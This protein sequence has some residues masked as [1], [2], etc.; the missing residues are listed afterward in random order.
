MDET[1][2]RKVFERIEQLEDMY[3]DL[4]RAA[5]AL[6]AISPVNGG[7]GELDKAELIERFLRDPC[8]FESIER[9]D[10][11]DE[12]AKDGVRPNIIARVGGSS[13]EPTLWLV[14]HCDIVPPGDL[15][16]WNSNPYM[17]HLEERR[18]YGRGTEDGLQGIAASAAALRAVMDV[19]EGPRLNV[20]LLIVSDEETGHKYGIEHVLRA[21]PGLFQP[22]DLVV[23]TSGGTRDGTWI[24]VAEKSIL[25]LRFT[26]SGE[27]TQASA[28]HLGTNS[29]RATAHLVVALEELHQRFSGENELFEPATSTFEP[30]KHETSVT[31]VNTVPGEEV[32]Y[33][34]CRLLPRYRMEDVKG[35]VDE[36]CDR[37]RRKLGVEIAVEVEKEVRAGDPTP[38]EAPVVEAA[39]R[40]VESVY[41]RSARPRGIGW[42]TPAAPIRAAGTPAIGYSRVDETAHLPNEYCDL[43]NLRGDA[44]VYAAM[45]LQG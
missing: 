8:A 27:Q 35:A 19:A 25:W 31:T 1:T 39:S 32:F 23:V 42:V 24:E 6:P 37:I 34:D 26:V 22:D 38:P 40:A 11:S 45:M 15:S 5:V 2:A 43:D 4:M 18:A 28:P 14:S 21:R 16:M 44:K 30:T 7:M 33:M 17:L 13:S 3:L 10:A 29:F 36:I 12:R 20:A 41:R 9:V